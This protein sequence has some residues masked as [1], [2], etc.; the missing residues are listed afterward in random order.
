MMS[1]RN[2]AR[3]G[4]ASKRGKAVVTY[5][6]PSA[7]HKSL[8][9][10]GGSEQDKAHRSHPPGRR[11]DLRR[12]SR[13]GATAQPPHRMMSCRNFA[14]QGK[15]SKRGKAV[16]TYGDPSASRAKSPVHQGKRARQGAPEPPSRRRSD[17]RRGSRRG[18]TQ[19]CDAYWMNIASPKEKKRYL[20]STA[21][22][23]AL[24]ISSLPARAETSIIRVLSG[25]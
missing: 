12:G 2:F 15:A 18:A 22:L 25:R 8:R 16:V 1:C 9:F 21:S 11:S 14:R 3:Q 7:S 4:K 6:D 17:L 24:I 19:Y 10:I 23:Y 5:G 13:R 20:F